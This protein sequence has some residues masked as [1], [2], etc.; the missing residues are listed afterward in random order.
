[1]GVN[2][3]TIMNWLK[4]IKDDNLLKSDSEISPE[5]RNPSEKMTLLLEGR[6]I[7]PKKLG[8]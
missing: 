7:E 5:S 8:K 6:S 3:Q 2:V 4:I 1:M